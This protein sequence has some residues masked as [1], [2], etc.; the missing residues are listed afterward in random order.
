MKC[1]IEALNVEK[2]FDKVKAVNGVT[3]KIRDGEVFGLLGTNGAG[4]STL[5]RMIAGILIPEHELSVSKI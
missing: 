2:S 1:M 5:L 3:L 4:K